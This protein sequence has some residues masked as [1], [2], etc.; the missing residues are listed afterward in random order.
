MTTLAQVALLL[1]L[2]AEPLLALAAD[3]RSHL[4]ARRSA[5]AQGGGGTG[6]GGLRRLPDQ[7]RLPDPRDLT[8]LTVVVPVH[9]DPQDLDRLGWLQGEGARVL[10]VT[11]ATQTPAFYRRLWAVAGEHGF[12]VHVAGAPRR[13]ASDREPSPRSVRVSLL[14]A[15]HS[16]LTSAYVVAVDPG[17]VITRPLGQVVEGLASAGLDV[18]TVTT[19]VHPH[20]L[21]AR[22]QRIE[23][24]V[25]ARLRHR[26]PWL[27]RGGAHVARRTVHAD[28]VRR[29]SGFGTGADVELGVLAGA[30]GH[31]VGALD[32]P[33]VGRDAGTSRAWW[34]HRLAEASGVFRVAVVHLHLG[35]RRPALHLGA[36]AGAFTLVPLLWWSA[37]HVPWVLLP[38]VVVHGALTAALTR[39]LRDPVAWVYPLY[40]VLRAFVLLPL[41]AVAYLVAAART[42][43]AGLLRVRDPWWPDAA[44]APVVRRLPGPGPARATDWWARP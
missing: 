19:T 1:T 14:D 16:V 36:A 10:L 22:V 24:A 11:T 38:V 44:D 4:R 2:L 12:R 43:D 31:R 29:L 27:V 40:A 30:R 32:V 18:G 34:R 15:A 42:G 41:G 35:V 21:L 23:D 6:A 25:A 33:A 26:V 28:L 37:L 9:G 3:V 7:R 8:D 39:D 13:R 20:G 5:G 17:T